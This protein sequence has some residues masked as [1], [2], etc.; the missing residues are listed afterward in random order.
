MPK[1]S[2]AEQLDLAISALLSAAQPLPDAN[3]SP[4]IA[5]LVSLVR[6]LRA[7]P[8]PDFKAALK[9]DLQRRTSMN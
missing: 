8:R 4:R 6:P 3:Q 1:R 5:A 9:S 2:P 7:L